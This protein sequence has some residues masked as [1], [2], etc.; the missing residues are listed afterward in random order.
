MADGAADPAAAVQIPLNTTTMAYLAIMRLR[1]QSPEAVW[2]SL[3][4]DTRRAWLRF[5]DDTQ[6]LADVTWRTLPPLARKRLRISMAGI[7]AL[8][9]N[10]GTDM[11]AA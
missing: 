7:L 2:E 3:S 10:I 6:G 11:V 9:A 5:G 4:F 1:E 8:L